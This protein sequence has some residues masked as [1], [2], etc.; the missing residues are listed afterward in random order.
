MTASFEIS[1]EEREDFKAYLR[2]GFPFRLGDIVV[3]DIDNDYDT[4]LLTK[5]LA[6]DFKAERD[7]IRRIAARRTQ[8][9]EREAIEAL[10]ER[11]ANKVNTYNSQ[12]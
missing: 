1:P 11:N 3:G 10:L 9:R 6:G 7:L 4:R 12:I 5:A 2:S 8:R